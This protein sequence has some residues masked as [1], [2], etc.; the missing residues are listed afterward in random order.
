MP[1]PRRDIRRFFVNESFEIAGAI[2]SKAT[3]SVRRYEPELFLVATF[4]N[5][6]ITHNADRGERV[7]QRIVGLERDP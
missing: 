7:S 2:G 5:L 1:G 6:T 3:D 4:Q